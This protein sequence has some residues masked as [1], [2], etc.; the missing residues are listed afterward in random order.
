MAK[1]LFVVRHS[2]SNTHA[3]SHVIHLLIEL[4]ITGQAL[5]KMLHFYIYIE[6]L[7][8]FRQQKRVKLV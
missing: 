5:P 8:R 2:S 1:R 7:V 4:Y 6:D 3:F